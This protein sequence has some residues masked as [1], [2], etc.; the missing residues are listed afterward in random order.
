MIKFD[1]ELLIIMRQ[2][3]G[4]CYAVFSIY[5]KSISPDKISHI[6]Q[7][8]ST[9]QY[10]QGEDVSTPWG[11]TVKS[12]QSCWFLS[13]QNKLH[14]KDLRAHLQ[15]LLDIIQPISFN[16][17][18]CKRSRIYKCILSASGFPVTERGAIFMAGAVAANGIL[19]LPC[20]FDFYCQEPMFTEPLVEIPTS[21]KDWNFGYLTLDHMKKRGWVLE[22]IQEAITTGRQLPA[23]N[24]IHKDNGAIRYIHP[25]TGKSII[26]DM[27]TRELIHIGKK[28]FLYPSDDRSFPRKT[29]KIIFLCDCLMREQ[30]FTGL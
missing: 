20:Y 13:S 19:G 15:W 7:L 16:I 8:N 3:C 9:E 14:S 11:K 30:L 4:E 5:S 21:R 26:I 6:L 23:N 2:T 12:P 28:D 29:C 24:H 25:Q 22:Q 18:R 17:K 27:V 1:I 10:M